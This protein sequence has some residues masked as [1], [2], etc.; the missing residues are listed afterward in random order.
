MCATQAHGLRPFPQ[1]ECACAGLPWVRALEASL[2]LRL[3]QANLRES[4]CHKGQVGYNRTKQ[5]RKSYLPIYL[6]RKEAPSKGV[7]A[8]MA[9]QALGVAWLPTS[10]E[11][12]DGA[13]AR[14]A[15]QSQTHGERKASAKS[16]LD[17]G[18]LNDCNAGSRLGSA[19]GAIEPSRAPS[20]PT[21]KQGG[22]SACRK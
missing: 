16:D 4:N 6:H 12:T 18:R 9:R 19:P 3:V 5:M 21:R 8:I 14:E 7:D 20:P 2:D 11:S 15:M 1:G 17:R 13:A 22:R 10:G